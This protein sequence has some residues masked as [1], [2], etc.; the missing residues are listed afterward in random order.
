MSNK[1]LTAAT[2]ILT[3]TFKSILEVMDASDLEDCIDV[4]RA[5]ALET[6][7]KKDIPTVFNETVRN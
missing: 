7:F 3:S 6:E 5:K 4:A 1:S 2:N